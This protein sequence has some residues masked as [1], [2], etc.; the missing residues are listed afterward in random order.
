MNLNIS[1]VINQLEA[2]VSASKEKYESRFITKFV[3]AIKIALLFI[4]R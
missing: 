2:L 4:I 1:L 3:V